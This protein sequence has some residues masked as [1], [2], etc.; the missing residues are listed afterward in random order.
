LHCV[1]LV[2]V[3]SY[4]LYFLAQGRVIS[5]KIHPSLLKLALAAA[6]LGGQPS[7]MI[8]DLLPREDL[9]S[10]RMKNE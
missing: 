9:S 8:N 2:A 3:T 7:L 10:T 1:L 6:R 5:H 4:D